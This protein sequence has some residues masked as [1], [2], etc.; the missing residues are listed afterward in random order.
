M[1]FFGFFSS[2]STENVFVL[3][4]VLDISCEDG[5]SENIHLLGYDLCQWDGAL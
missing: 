3:N 5:K 4:D 2:K 1:D